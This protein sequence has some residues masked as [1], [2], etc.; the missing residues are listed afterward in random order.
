M[1]ADPAYKH[2]SQGFSR[3]RGVSV[4]ALEDLGM[5]LPFSISGDFEILYAS[6]GG[7]QLAGVGPPLGQ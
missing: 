6:G 3:L 4:V 5:E 1:G 2:L 7:H